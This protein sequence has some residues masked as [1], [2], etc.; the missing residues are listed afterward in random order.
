MM[1]TFIFFTRTRGT[2]VAGIDHTPANVRACV[3]CLSRVLTG[4]RWLA[5]QGPTSQCLKLWASPP[6]LPLPAP[7]PFL[8]LPCLLRAAAGGRNGG[9]A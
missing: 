5:L 1:I 9:G 2:H 6:V 4:L 7:P 3:G 8:C